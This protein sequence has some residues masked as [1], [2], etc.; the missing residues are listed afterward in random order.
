MEQLKLSKKKIYGASAEKIAAD[1]GQISFF[2]EAEAE[3]TPMLPEPKVEDVIRKPHKKKKRSAKEMY[4][5]LEVVEKIYELP[6]EELVCPK[7]DSEM[8]FM[9]WRIK[10]EIEIIPAQVKL[11]VHKEAVYV[12]KECDKNG[13]EGSFKY[14]KSVP[15][16][17]EKSLVSPS[18]M[19]WIMNQK[20]CLALPLY[21]QEQ[22]LKRMGANLSRQTMSN[23]TIAGAKL[24]KPLY[25]ALHQNLLARNILHADETV[26]EVLKLSDRDKP[27]DAYMWVYR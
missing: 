19:A 15:S 8:T 1:Y 16:L 10:N 26:L 11:I 20:F 12:C 5:N 23:W 25:D 17:I 18:L 24:L 27:L 2:N 21:R 9:R 6:K 22:E 4:K 14:A 7:C 13:I 3:R